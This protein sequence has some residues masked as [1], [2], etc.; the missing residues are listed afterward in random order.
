M[1][2]NIV[3]GPSPSND[4]AAPAPAQPTGGSNSL[5]L[6]D[7]APDTQLQTLVRP[8][9]PSRPNQKPKSP[10]P[11]LPST[12]QPC[13]SAARST[14]EISAEE[15]EQVCSKPVRRMLRENMPIMWW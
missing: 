5:N 11:V 7:L 4:A 15:E 8:C 10:G 9:L 1:E 2:S 14:W 12:S 3:L 6:G 13:P